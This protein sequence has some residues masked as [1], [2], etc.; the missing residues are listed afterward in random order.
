MK[1]LI[2]IT[3]N[4]GK[5]AVSARELYDFLGLDKSN[6]KRW[7]VKNIETNDFSEEGVDWV[8]LVIETN[9]QGGRPTR[10]FALSLDFAKKLSMIANT[11]KGEEARNYFIAC[12][13]KLK[14]VHVIPQTYSE[15]LLL[16]SRQAEQIELQ[17]AEL[18]MQAPKV[19]Y[20]DE[21][22][23]SNSL[24]STTTIAKELGLTAQN[25]NKK[26]QEDKVIFKQNGTFVLFSKYQDKG[27]SGTKTT[28]YTDS[29]G[30]KKSNILLYWTEEG[31]KFILN[32]YMA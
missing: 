17:E 10:D 29:I 1:E 32:R 27:Y 24:I 19:V 16:A 13:K 23:Q 14:E 18:R 31:R 30:S 3:N 11:P 7:Y 4:N 6:Y 21:V 2:K 26:L 8:V 25:L 28:T 20:H 22:L 12:E 5:S 9:T 15:A